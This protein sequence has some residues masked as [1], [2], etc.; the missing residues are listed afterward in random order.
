MAHLHDMAKTPKFASPDIITTQK[1]KFQPIITQTGTYT[2]NAA[3]VA[4][5]WMLNICW[6][7]EIPH[8]WKLIYILHIQD[9]H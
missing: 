8:W 3:Q 7:L 5:Y 2:Y 4:A 6:I 1:S 9:Y